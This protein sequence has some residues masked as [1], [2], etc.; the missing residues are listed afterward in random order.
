MS[1]FNDIAI[2]I[3]EAMTVAGLAAIAMLILYIW[4][5]ELPLEVFK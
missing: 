4:V 1:K 2:Y 3:F 5:L